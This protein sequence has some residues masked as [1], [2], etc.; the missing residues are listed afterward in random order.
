MT[1]QSIA[2]IGAGNMASAIIGGL[3]ENGYPASLISAADPYQPQLDK[4]SAKGVTTSQSNA[5]VIANADVVVFAVKPQSMAKLCADI[6]NNITEENPLLISIAAGITSSMF[7]NWLSADIRLV[8]CMPNTPA[9]VQT[10]ATGLFA[11]NNVSHEQKR[12]AEEL[13][14]AIGIATWVETE[15]LID[16]VTAVSGSGPA[17]FFLM[18]ESMIE[19]GQKLGLSFDAAKALTI[20]TALGAAKM[21]QASDDEPAELRRK[22][23]SPNGTTEAAIKSFQA[24]NFEALVEEALKAAD[25]RSK[26]LAE[27]MRS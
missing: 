12:F 27:E 6:K 3:I 4:L 24:N 17:Y 21:A 2:F 23:T 18:I 5:E 15:D 26:T 19:A 16:A 20:Q 22:V 25:T 7:E 10:G 8:R 11:N 14:G 13:L 1:Q 9:L